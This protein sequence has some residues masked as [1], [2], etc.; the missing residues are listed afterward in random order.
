MK[1]NEMKRKKKMKIIPSTAYIIW[2][3]ETPFFFFLKIF[4]VAPKEK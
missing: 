2:K 4:D 3:G 1:R